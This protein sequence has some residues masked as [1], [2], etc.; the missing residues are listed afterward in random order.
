MALDLEQALEVAERAALEA[1]AMVMQGFRAETEVSS[2]GRFDLVTEY[3][4]RSE[5]L[6]GE[7]LRAAFPDHRIVG[8][9][10]EP[11]G[12]GDLVWYVDPIDGTVNFA[13]GH[14]YFCVSIGL[15]RESE[16]LVGV[17]VAPALGHTWKAARGLG[18]YRDDAPIQVSSRSSLEEALCTTGFPGDFAN[19]QDTNTAELAAFL[20]AARGVRRCGS[21]ALDLALVGDGTYDVYWERDLRPWDISAGAMLVEEAG[22]SLSHYDGSTADPRTGELVATNGALHEEVLELIGSARS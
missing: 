10:G 9:E 2:K 8:E 21:A 13:H 1:G 4:V 20:R 17:L 15:Y 19:T 18:A 6:I 12:T 22:G 5:A 7:H 16:G 14:P 3:D 11:I